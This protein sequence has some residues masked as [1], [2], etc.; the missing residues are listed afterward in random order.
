MLKDQLIENVGH[1][2]HL[3]PIARRPA[4][5]GDLPQYDDNWR[6]ECVDDHG[7]RLQNLSTDQ[8]ILLTDDQIH[9]Y[10]VN[11]GG[12]TDKH[13]PGFLH[14]RVQINLLPDGLETEPITAGEGDESRHAE[15]ALAGEPMRF[16]TLNDPEL[17][18]L[19]D[20]LR[21]SGEEPCLP[22]FE[23]RDTKLNQGFR[24]A[25]YPGT[26]REILIGHGRYM[27]LLMFK[28]ADK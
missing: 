24:V 2:V 25:L 9:S 6:I 19:M 13:K 22:L 10:E 23:D 16:T 8:R 20:Q 28:P 27:A 7:V 12:D 18:R 26:D 21:K 15:E 11:S 14:L 3:R 5:G 1:I 17:K 4:V